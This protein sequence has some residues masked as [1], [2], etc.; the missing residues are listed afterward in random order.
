MHIIEMVSPLP[1]GPLGHAG[2][3]PPAAVADDPP[4]SV[5]AT[6]SCDAEQ[7]PE[8]P[9]DT[10][11]SEQELPDAPAPVDRQVGSLMHLVQ[12][13]S[14]RR[15]RQKHVEIIGLVVFLLCMGAIAYAIWNLLPQQLP[16]QP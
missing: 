8:P 3:H 9:S 13:H 15:T 6:E 14:Q 4:A 5:A 12:K 7:S 11:A 10:A 2:K 16:Q 1:F